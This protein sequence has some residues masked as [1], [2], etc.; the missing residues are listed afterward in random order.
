MSEP[1]RIG[2][3]QPLTLPSIRPSV[4]RR[5]VLGG[6]LGGLLGTGLLS[7]C[8]TTPHRDGHGLGPT[9]GP[10][11]PTSPA[12]GQRVVERTLTPQVATVDLGGPTVSTWVFGDTVPGPLI[13]ATAGDF[14]RI[15]VDN[16]LPA[17][18]TVHW[19]GIR[20]RNPADGVPGLTQDPI[21]QNASYTYEFTVPDPGTYWFH[22][23]VGVQLDRGLYGALVVDDPREPGGY[24]AEWV[25]VIDDW[26]DGLGRTP[27]DVLAGLI[28]GGHTM[29]GMGGHSMGG[30]TMGGPG[31]M[32][33][34]GMDEQGMPAEGM[35]GDVTYPHFLIN[36]RVPAA[37]STFTAKPGQRVR[38][39]VLN[40]A[41][42]TIFALALGGHR[43]TVTH[44]DGYAVVPHE[45]GAL[46][47]GMGERYDLVVTLGDGIFPLVAK[48]YG[49]AGQALALVRT[50]SGSAPGADALPAELD[51]PAMR[52]RELVP[53]EASRL[54]AREADVTLPYH[55]AG[56]MGSYTW[57]INGAAYGENAPL[58]VS[59]GQRARL[60]IT[61]QTM[62]AHPV[63]LHG[64]TFAVTGS[65]LRK[66]TL[67]VPPMGS[68]AIEFQADNPGRW[69][70]HCHNTYHA[71][72]GMMIELAY[73]T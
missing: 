55:M 41:S 59:A 35:G 6:A 64:H 50:G 1:T 26:L 65:G 36:G 32:G 52:A 67:V 22:P 51:G 12:P 69:M 3:P 23:H 37:P 27:D 44:S 42:D 46:L 17:P 31:G 19:H 18:T 39:R 11:T 40:A 49:K 66:D 14:L 60:S 5:S 9:F 68:T 29:G 56:G 15:R 8:T 21:G 13:R 54:P 73:R 63:H 38:I 53:A 20:L 34:M 57:T 70:S 61:N 33:G 30:H 10:P 72:A 47:I 25:V 48:P 24:D 4:T 45:I 16:Q 28:A 7:G 71:E 2:D 58:L 43:L 62:M